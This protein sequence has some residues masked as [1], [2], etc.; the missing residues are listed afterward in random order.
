[1]RPRASGDIE[2]IILKALHKEPDR[3]YQTADTLAAQR[4]DIAW[5]F[6]IADEADISPGNLY[7]HFRSRDDITLELIKRFQQH[8][9]KL[10]SDEEALMAFIEKHQDE[11]EWD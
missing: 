7:Y 6:N 11:I 2:T 8:V 4:P 5:Q 9:L 10:V 1:M 3:R